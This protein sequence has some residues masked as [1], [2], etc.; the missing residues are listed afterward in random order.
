MARV[1]GGLGFSPDRCR[2]WILQEAR[3]ID[4]HTATGVREAFLHAVELLNLYTIH[5]FTEVINNAFTLALELNITVY[6]A[7]FLSLAE[8]LDMQLL[9]LDRKL[10][11]KLQGTKY[12]STIEYPKSST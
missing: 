11:N 5:N 2:V 3:I 12:Y 9:T 7:S 6:D 10:A 1:G 4:H 8:K